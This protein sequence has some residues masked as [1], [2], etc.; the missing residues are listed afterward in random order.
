MTLATV[1]SSEK[2]RS[3]FRKK[4]ASKSVATLQAPPLKKRIAKPAHQPELLSD[5]SHAS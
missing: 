3:P 2:Q 1:P 5:W 4:A